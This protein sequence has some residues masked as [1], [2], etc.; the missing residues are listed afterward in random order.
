MSVPETPH[1]LC[2]VEIVVVH[3]AAFPYVPAL[4]VQAARAELEIGELELAGHATHV[5]AAVAPVVVKYVPAAQS[6]HAAEPVGIL[7]LP[8]TQAVHEPAGPVY[9]ALQSVEIQAARAELPGREV[10]VAG[11]VTQV[12][13]AVAAVVVEYVPVG[14]VLHAALRMKTFA[15]LRR[16][17]IVASAPVCEPPTYTNLF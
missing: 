4:H 15:P 12:A 11:H 16:F 10:V 8:A 13:A 5:A 2:S 6:V 17:K 9:P 3:D 14:H 1:D 7:Y